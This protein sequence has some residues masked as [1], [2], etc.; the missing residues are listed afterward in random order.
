MPYIRI[1]IYNIAPKKKAFCPK[2][3]CH[4]TIDLREL[5]VLGPRNWL[6]LERVD[7]T[8]DLKESDEKQ[9]LPRKLLKNFAPQKSWDWK[10]R[11][12]FSKWSLFRE[13]F[14]LGVCRIVP[15]TWIA[16]G[17]LEINHFMNLMSL[18]TPSHLAIWPWLFW[19]L[20]NHLFGGTVRPDNFESALKWF[21]AFG[22][23]KLDVF[24]LCQWGRIAF[25]KD[26]AYIYIQTYYI[27]TLCFT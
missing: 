18:E 21:V 17:R 9:K 8:R 20:K 2:K 27:Y 25:F 26:F 1:Y 10:T 6:Y 14:I 19:R 12:S 5:L 15:V 23:K 22:Q 16:H 7:E 4:P 13:P 11:L 24:V 3:K